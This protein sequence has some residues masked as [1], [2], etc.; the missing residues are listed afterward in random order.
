MKH[1]NI[2]IFIPHAG[3]PHR[4]SFCDQNAITAQD[5]LPRGEDVTR[6]CEQAFSQ[7]DDLTETEIAFFGGS[8]TAIPRRYML[9]ILEAAKPFAGRCKG[10]RI[11]TRPDCVD[12]EVLAILREFHITSIELGAQSLDDT[13]L[14]LNERGHTAQDVRDASA[15]IREAGFELGLQ[16][17]PGLYGA[18]QHSDALTR[19][20]VLAIHPDTVRIYPVV[21]L[22]GTRLGEWYESGVYQPRPFAA[23][24]GEVADAMEAFLAAGIRVIKIGLHASEFV[25]EHAL[26]GYYHPAFRELCESAVYRRRIAHAIAGRGTGAWQVHVHPACI[27]KAVGQKRANIRYFH[28]ICGADIRIIG[29]GDV[30]PFQVKIREN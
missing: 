15:R 9:E 16:I 2:A 3:C 17:M 24:V 26:G 19:E 20:A 28:D 8:F 6:I 14:R 23:M 18:S 13:V 5:A 30:P 29:D 12:R 21:I 22:R 11:S 27:S 1:K 7:I 4:C 25:A 10:I